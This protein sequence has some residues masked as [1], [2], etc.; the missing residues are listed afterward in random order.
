M[1]KILLGKEVADVLSDDVSRRVAVLN[2][3][4]I[5]PTLAV[6]RVGERPDDLS[7]ERGVVK[8][9]EKVG[10]RIVSVVLP[11]DADQSQLED[12]IVRVNQDE[13]IHGCLMFRPLPSHID[14]DRVCSLLAPEKD[15]DAVSAA[16]LAGVF[17]DLKGAFAPSTAA[18]CMKVLDHYGIDVAGRKVAVVGR[19]LVVGK[20]VAMLLLARNATVT[21]CHSKTDDLE[22]TVRDADIVIC[23]TGRAR[24]F[25]PAFFRE[26]QVVIDVGINVD[27]DGKLCG[28]VNYEAVEGI[29]GA[30]TPVPRGVGSVTSAIT[31]EHTVQAAERLLS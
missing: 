13:G 8:R 17:A 27:E 2:E 10:A 22:G 26:G 21:I 7:Y 14:E 29:V 11:A 4:G 23:A 18:A 9:A 15:V 19:S 1:S 28:D 31:P 30:I 3:A 6:V 25:G 12:A 5:E 20:P 16:A 24:M